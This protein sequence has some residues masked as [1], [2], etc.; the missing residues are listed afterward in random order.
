MN[1]EAWTELHWWAVLA[2]PF[3]AAFAVSIGNSAELDVEIKRPVIGITGYVLAVG[4]VG[5]GAVVGA[6]PADAISNVILFSALTY[7]AI[8]DARYLA[9]PVGAVLVLITAGL[10][11]TLMLDEDTWMHAAASLGGYGSFR[12]LDRLYIRF[13]GRSGLGAGDALIAAA[14]GAWL[15]PERL[16]WAVAVGGMLLLAWLGL[17]TTASNKALPFAPALALGALLTLVLE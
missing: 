1:I 6:S 8:V 3:L 17:T 7:L 10:A 12:L 11:K 2:A 4:G 5:V 14:I 16:A 9:V 15:G 13:R